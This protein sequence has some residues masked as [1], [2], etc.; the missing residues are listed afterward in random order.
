[1]A[2]RLPVPR[3]AGGC[4][5]RSGCKF[6]DAFAC[7][8][9]F[10]VARPCAAAVRNSAAVCVAYSCRLI[11]CLEA[12]STAKGQDCFAIPLVQCAKPR[13]PPRPSEW[14]PVGACRPHQPPASRVPRSL[15]GACRPRQPPACRGGYAPPERGRPPEPPSRAA[16]TS[17]TAGG[18]SL[19][20]K[21][22]RPQPTARFGGRSL[23][24]GAPSVGL[25]SVAR[26]VGFAVAAGQ[27]PGG[28]QTLTFHLAGY[29][30][31]WQHCSRFLAASPAKR[32]AV[33]KKSS[34]PMFRAVVSMSGSAHS[35][36]PVNTR[37]VSPELR[38][39]VSR[40]GLCLSP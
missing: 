14:P 1:M 24:Y 21:P 38:A 6:R 4:P 35:G 17:C 7:R 23:R 28:R 3:S 8:N 34:A 10:A 15:A 5:W 22:L 18:F 26:R 20:P 13:T 39:V 27:R 12:D 16:A 11:M 25:P 29:A 31:A 30:R 37:S 36:R 33:T 19:A 32:L 9:A 2:L 40:V